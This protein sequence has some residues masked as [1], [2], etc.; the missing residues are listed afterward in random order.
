MRSTGCGDWRRRAASL[1][2]LFSDPRA[3]SQSKEH[4]AFQVEKNYGELISAALLLLKTG[5]VLLASTNAADWPP[6]KFLDVVEG[7]I[8][9]AKKK[10]LQKHYAPQPP[11]FPISRNEPAYLKT[12]TDAGRLGQNCLLVTQLPASFRT[13]CAFRRKP[14]EHIN[15]KISVRSRNLRRNSHHPIINHFR[16]PASVQNTAPSFIAMLLCPNLCCHKYEQPHAV[17]P[18]S[19]LLRWRAEQM[20]RATI[21]FPACPVFSSVRTPAE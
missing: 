3:F 19:T 16:L 6:E 21:P 4:G 2:Q 1:I 12:M 14:R 7:S 10:V 5:G 9:A 15:S 13:A 20:S 17:T 8:R 18:A 11:D